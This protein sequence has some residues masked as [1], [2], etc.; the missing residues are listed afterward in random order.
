MNY[1]KLK[2]TGKK[3]AIK[4]MAQSQVKELPEYEGPRGGKYYFDF[5]YFGSCNF[6]VYQE[7]TRRD[8][9]VAI[10]VVGYTE[11]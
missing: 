3:V 1:K 8:V 11:D 9:R 4:T 7:R 6:D 2:A 5:C 10:N